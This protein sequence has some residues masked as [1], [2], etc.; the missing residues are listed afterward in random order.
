MAEEVGKYRGTTLYARVMTELVQAAQYRGVTTYQD[1]A[2]IM[3]LPTEGHHMGNE[4][5]LMLDEISRDETRA[6]RP[7]LSAVVVRTEGVPGP[8]F[9]KLAA[10]LGLV[11]S[12]DTD[13]LFW[14][15]QREAVYEA[16]K[17][18]IR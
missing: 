16:W 11:E 6:G 7:M 12:A 14:M 13:T 17:R 10:D 8:G 5:G 1:I 15:K 4:I 3:G 9:Y 18:P 2:L